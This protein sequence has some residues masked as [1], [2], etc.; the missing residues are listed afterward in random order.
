MRIEVL[1]G[2]GLMIWVFSLEV[3]AQGDCP[4][5]GQEIDALRD[6]AISKSEFSLVRALNTCGAE[7]AKPADQKLL[8]K[9]L[10]ILEISSTADALRQS[11]ADKRNRTEQP[12]FLAAQEREKRRQGNGKADNSYPLQ[13]GYSKS[14]AQLVNRLP[15]R[16][17]TY[18]TRFED[19]L[20]ANANATNDLLLVIIRQNDEIISLLKERKGE[21][22]DDN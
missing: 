8:S 14:A 17:G 16:S 3:R 1:L 9:A 6:I 19:D 18:P 11:A 22:P 15:N 10:E 21:E 12:W 4:F 13:H 2:I 7:N 5:S 20:V